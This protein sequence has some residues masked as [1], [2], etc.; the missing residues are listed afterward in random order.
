MSFALAV[1]L[2]KKY[3]LEPVHLFASAAHAPNVSQR[4]INMMKQNHKLATKSK[5]NIL[6]YGM[7][8]SFNTK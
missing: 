2:R 8:T 7:Q 3:G 4:I 6:Q 1:H 5:N